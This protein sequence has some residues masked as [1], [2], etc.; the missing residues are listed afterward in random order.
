MLITKI[1]AVESLG[2]VHPE[3]QSAKPGFGGGGGLA[4]LGGLKGW[5]LAPRCCALPAGGWTCLAFSLAQPGLFR[6]AFISKVTARM[7]SFGFSIQSVNFRNCESSPPSQT[8]FLLPSHFIVDLFF[9]PKT[10]IWPRKTLFWS[11]VRPARN[12]VHL[13]FQVAPNKVSMD[14]LGSPL[15]R[16]GRKGGGCLSCLRGEDEAGVL[17]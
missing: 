12:L 13:S 8:L 3:W 9:S 10:L 1:L 15:G 6:A 16:S 5:A 14:L 4:S 2:M 17:H 11:R 7:L